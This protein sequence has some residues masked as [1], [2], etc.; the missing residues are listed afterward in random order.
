[1]TWQTPATK[2][3]L[4]AEL[5]RKGSSPQFTLQHVTSKH[6]QDPP[7]GNTIL[8]DAGLGALPYSACNNVV[9]V[10]GANM[11]TPRWLVVVF[12]GVAALLVVTFLVLALAYFL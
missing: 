12:Y 9:G 1:M 10:R 4:V 6:S 7:R 2:A 5:P 8:V 11:E 3:G